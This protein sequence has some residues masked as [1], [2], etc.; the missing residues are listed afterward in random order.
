M[1]VYTR[2]GILAVIVERGER[3]ARRYVASAS[4]RDQNRRTQMQQVNESERLQQIADILHVLRWHGEWG[5]TAQ[6]IKAELIRR[7]R[8]TT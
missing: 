5:Q 7:G 4:A 2:E 6:S 1:D 3:W 8:E